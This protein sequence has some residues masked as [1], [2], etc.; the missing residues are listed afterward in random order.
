MALERRSTRL[1]RCRREQGLVE[2]GWRE[3]RD[4]D[5]NSVITGLIETSGFEENYHAWGIRSRTVA[6]QGRCGD[7]VVVDFGSCA[8][9]VHS[10]SRQISAVAGRLQ[11]QH[12]RA[13]P[14]RNQCSRVIRTARSTRQKSGGGRYPE[15]DPFSHPP[16]T[17]RTTTQLNNPPQVCCDPLCDLTVYHS[18]GAGTPAS[19]VDRDLGGQQGSAIAGIC[20]SG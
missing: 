14:S 16:P 4:N 1:G 6:F 10:G 7:K 20:F 5:V 19:E 9:T 13:H 18:P 17:D 11:P 15:S 8:R 3:S 2:E 12:S